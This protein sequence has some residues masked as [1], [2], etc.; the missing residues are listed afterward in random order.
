MTESVTLHEVAFQAKKATTWIAA[1]RPS[2]GFAKR[3]PSAAASEHPEAY[4]DVF[5]ASLRLLSATL[6][7]MDSQEEAAQ[8]AEE[9][10]RVEID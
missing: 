3:S 5:Q 8:L 9:A 1:L 2:T 7:K 4:V 10:A 6:R